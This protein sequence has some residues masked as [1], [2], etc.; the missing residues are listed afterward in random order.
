MKKVFYPILALALLCLSARAGKAENMAPEDTVTIQIGKSKK[1]IIWVD[2]KKDLVGL[3]MYDLNKMIR[4]I[5]RTV[6]S[7]DHANQ[8]LIVTDENG[9]QYKIEADTS[10]IGSDWYKHDSDTIQHESIKLGVHFNRKDQSEKR[11]GD[12]KFKNHHFGTRHHFE[13][14]LGMNN[15]LD[16]SNQFPTGTNAVRPW[17]SWFVGVNSNWRTHVA[18]PLALQWGAGMNWYNFKFEDH[19]TRLEKTAEEVQFVRD[20]SGEI[21]ARKSKLTATYLNVNLVPMLDFRYKTRY[22]RDEN[23][24]RRVERNYKGD[25]FRI[26]LGG[27]AGYRIS[28]YTKYKFDESRKTRREKDHDNFY[29]NNLRYGMRL[30]LGFKGVDIFANYDLNSLFSENRG[31][32]LYAISFGITL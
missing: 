28:S 19:R 18:G 31:P 24:Q 27:Y 1:I 6:D 32:E 26:G 10:E 21:D 9:D 8:I 2:D 23:G 15:Y 30:Q 3:Q 20:I 11:S 4:D 17:G 14:D 12:K 13:F 25:A 5:N 22:V 16:G 29:M 7:L